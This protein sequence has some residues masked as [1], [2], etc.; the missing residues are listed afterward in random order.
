MK[1]YTSLE[2]SKKLAEIL[3][4][5]ADM[6]YLSKDGKG[7]EFFE[8]PVVNDGTRDDDDIPCWSLAPL[9]AC[10]PSGINIDGILYVFESHNTFDNEW[11]Y[12][13]KFE[14]NIAIYI[15]SKNEIDACVELIIKLNEQKLL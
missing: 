5:G 3:P 7:I 12:E 6:W 14:D 1:A 9:R 13:Y 11:V 2:Q 15:K 10:L 4:L 8:E